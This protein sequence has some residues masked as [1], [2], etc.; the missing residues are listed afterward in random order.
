MDTA[1]TLVQAFGS[2][3][4]SAEVYATVADVS[5]L[6]K[7]AAAAKNRAQVLQIA[8]KLRT[9]NRNIQKLLDL[10][11][12]V[13]SGKK[14]LVSKDERIYPQQFQNVVD[15][16]DHVTR[17]IDYLY[18]MMRRARL[19]NNSLTATGLR[20]LHSYNEP[21][22]DLVDWLDALAKTEQIE[23]IFG[24]AKRERKRGELFA[25]ARNE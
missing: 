8:M 20:T 23:A 18:E 4:A 14:P 1:A 15:N 17:M 7:L 21:L 19:T 25:L 12:E 6:A 22:K 16:L 3:E 13:E 2:S 24:R 9:T 10:L 11:R 5:T